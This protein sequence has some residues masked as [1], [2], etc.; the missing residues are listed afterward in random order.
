MTDTTN[1]ILLLVL[2]LVVF[3]N[4]L[5]VVGGNREI[6]ISDQKNWSPEQSPDW[7]ESAPDGFYSDM[8]LA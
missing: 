7:V 5:F 6:S 2:Y 8:K 1:N 3:D 4:Q